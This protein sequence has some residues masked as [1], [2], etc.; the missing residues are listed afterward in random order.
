MVNL[1]PQVLVQVNGDEAP[2]VKLAHTPDPALYTVA[3]ARQE[4]TIRS[5]AIL[6]ALTTGGLFAV[7]A[8]A[9]SIASATYTDKQSMR[10]ESVYAGACASCH[11]AKLEGGVGPTLTGSTFAA[12]WTGKKASELVIRIRKTM[13]L[14]NPGSLS[15]AKAADVTAYILKKSDVPAGKKALTESSA[16]IIMAG[17]G[18]R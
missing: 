13:P 11:G 9:A 7:A 1:L 3:V 15:A 18:R 14:S 5:T 6:S 10:G 17:K 8:A 2:T 16:D 12:K 4:L